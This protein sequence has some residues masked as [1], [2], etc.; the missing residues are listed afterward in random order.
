M[1]DYPFIT[2]KNT[3]AAPVCGQD[4]LEWELSASSFTYQTFSGPM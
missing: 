4:D 2:K 3:R 1:P